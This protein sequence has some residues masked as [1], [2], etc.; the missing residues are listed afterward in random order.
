MS[1]LK[2]QEE[3]ISGSANISKKTI[4]GMV[5]AALVLL[6]FLFIPATDA[7]S[8]QGIR[9]IGIVIAFLLLLITE[10]LPITVICWLL[11]GLMPVY[12]ATASFSE[13]LTGFSN[14]VVFFILASFVIAAA[15]TTIP[16]SKRMLIM[17]LKRFGKSVN[18]MLFAMMLCAAIISSIVSNVPTCAIAMSIGLSFL[19]LYDDET[20]KKSAGKAFMIGI[21]VASMIGGMM[22]P[23]GSSINLLAIGLLEQF[24]GKTIT[25]VEWM[26]V[27]MPLT[28][29]ALPIAWLIIVKVYKPAEISDSMV[30]RFTASLEIAPKM[31][32]P[33]VKVLLITALMLVLWIMSS[34]VRS[35]NVMVVALLGGCLMF[36]PGIRVLEWKPFIRDVNLDSF[37]LVGAVLSMGNAM[38][39]NG[40][41]DWIITLLPNFTTSL[42][43]LIAFT[44]LLIFALLVV[45][46]VA[47]S[48]VTLMASPLIALASGMGYSPQIIIL[49]LGLCAANCYLLPLDTVTL[50]TYGTGYYS[51]LDMPKSTLPIQLVIVALMTIWLPIA[52]RLVGLA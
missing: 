20:M 2:S 45:I 6:V 40:V 49:T 23:A 27:G 3:A 11:L 9:T 31:T 41:S 4:F 50:L 42:P 14:Q 51:M 43:V 46:P 36:F 34:W 37:F 16:L 33:E 7:L 1:K 22:T 10:S 32:A 12:G 15:F 5:S 39:K 26:I 48:L 29:V 18:S 47:P 30:S 24:T 28:L 21:P 13:A 19:E 44:V 17:L 52:G 38:V 25:F 8:L 35:I